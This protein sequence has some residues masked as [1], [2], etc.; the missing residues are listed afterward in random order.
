MK[1]ERLNRRIT[2]RQY[3]W[4]TDADSH[5][6]TKQ[7]LASHVVWAEWKGLKGQEVFEAELAREK[8]IGRGSWIIRY[9][10]D[11]TSKGWDILDDQGRVWDIAGEPREF[12]NR[13]GLEI[14]VE[15]RS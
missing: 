4:G 1:F 10:T 2:L 9:R 7:V 8:A 5:E 14:A 15:R 6:E 11:V 3:S 12:G 13:E